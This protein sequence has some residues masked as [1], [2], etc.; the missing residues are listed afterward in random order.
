M[1]EFDDYSNKKNSILLSRNNSVALVVGAAGFMGSHLAE[2]LLR[3][4][5]Q[6]IGVDDLASGKKINL[7][8]AI[9]DKNFHFLEDGNLRLN[10][11]RLDYIFITA[12]GLKLSNILDLAGK[13]GSKVVLLS[14]I[15][16]YDAEG[17]ED[18][19]WYKQAES[20]VANFAGVHKLNARVVRLAA[21]FGPRMDFNSK[22]P[23]VRLIAAALS[24]KLQKQSSVSEFSTRALYIDDAISLILKSMLSGATAQKIFDGVA[25]S[26]VS[27]SEIKQV[28]QDPIWY[29]SKGFDPSELPP[30]NTPNLEKTV[31]FLS[32]KPQTPL[33]KA[34]R[35]TINYF[36][37]NEIKIEELKIPAREFFEPEKEQELAKFKAKEESN[38]PQKK[39]N[40]NAFFKW[41]GVGLIMYGL[42]IP[43]LLLGLAVGEY[44]SKM[45]EAWVQLAKG[46]F[47]K[48]QENTKAARENLSKVREFIDLME[49]AKDLPYLGPYLQAQQQA[50]L[51]AD[52]TANAT[53]H[54]ATATFELYQGL[55]SVTGELSEPPETHFSASAQEF[56]QAQ[57]LVGKAEALGQKQGQKSS[58]VGQMSDLIEGGRLLS[59]LMPQITGSG[60]KKTYLVLVQDNQQLRPGGGVVTAY[61]R[62]DFEAGKLKGVEVNDVAKIDSGLGIHVEPPKE[63]RQDAAIEDWLLKDASWEPDFP[64]SARQIEWF[65][66]KET[67]IRVDGVLALDIT[68]LAAL[69]GVS[70]PLNVPDYGSGVSKD[71]LAASAMA[72]TKLAAG[73]DKKSFLATVL[74]QE[75]T[76]LFFLPNQ[77]W[78]G[79]VSSLGESLAEKHAAVYLDDPKLFAYLAA[80]NWAAVLPRPQLQTKEGELQDLL[81]V[82]EANMGGNQVNYYLERSWQLATNIDK[83]GQVSHRLKVNY[84]NRS[85]ESSPGGSYKNR[86]RLYLPFGARINRVLVGESDITAQLSSFSDYG[87]SGYSLIFEI[88]PKETKAMVVD[89]QLSGNL[90][91]AQNQAIYRLDLIKQ[92]GTAQDPLEWKLTFPSSYQLISDDGQRSSPQ[93]LNIKTDLSQDRRFEVTLKR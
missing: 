82:V 12:S 74:N 40:L 21:V 71:N 30:W 52:L 4:N 11:P 41:V 73:E 66:T 24:N 80:Q 25:R 6:V 44:Q 88:A 15:G 91:F 26:P 61:G 76:W 55:K 28:L 62:L 35:E 53:A 58:K 63:L 72:Y 43:L 46:E 50:L 79:V 27:V 34:L 7:D 5:I 68:A 18:L 92:L 20:E 29:E 48:A 89:Y 67:G 38:P 57:E 75:F 51:A 19:R 81:A 23:M 17:E 32:W 93:E 10:V 33:V 56:A 13:H 77:N 64:S 85:P 83:E 16:L 84:T 22:D 70:G 78:S 9:K 1:A 8:K 39:V 86:V 54:A 45:G 59:A 49:V 87:R 69:L 37:D 31:K 14:S 2:E 65:Y 47:E 3:K 36:K 42:V 90:T 60:S